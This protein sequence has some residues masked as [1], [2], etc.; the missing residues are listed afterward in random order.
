MREVDLSSRPADI[1]QENLTLTSGQTSQHP[2]LGTS[3]QL[4]KLDV[5]QEQTLHRGWFLQV[6]GVGLITHAPRVRHH[7]SNLQRQQEMHGSP[8]SCVLRDNRFHC[9][10]SSSHTSRRACRARTLIQVFTLMTLVA[11]MINCSRCYFVFASGRASQFV[12]CSSQQ[13]S[14]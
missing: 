3:L 11:S 8:K 1:C 10:G 9:E 7:E 5:L 6:F 4:S 2:P 13:F 14:D 12:H